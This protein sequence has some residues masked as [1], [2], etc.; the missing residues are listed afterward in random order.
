M[1]Q[2]AV[3]DG[4]M[5]KTHEWLNAIS[6]ELGFRNDRSALAALRATLHAVRDRLTLDEMAQFGAQ[7]P[8]LVRGLYYEGWNPNWDLL[9]KSHDTDF[10]EA[11]RRELK[12][13]DELK[14]VARVARVVLKVVSQ[15][16]SSDEVGQ[17]IQGLPRQVRELW[18][19]ARRSPPDSEKAQASQRE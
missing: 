4:T 19:E 14:D 11:V 6:D 8:I 18:E 7:L 1:P 15:K 5:H 16:M 2:S 3:L 9:R 13:H 17:A 12:G 10:I